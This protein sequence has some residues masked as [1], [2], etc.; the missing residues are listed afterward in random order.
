MAAPQTGTARTVADMSILSKW[1]VAT[2]HPVV[3][4]DLGA[5]HRITDGAIDRW[6]T[7]ATATYIA[8]CPKLEERRAGAGLVLSAHMSSHAGGMKLGGATSV[9]VS[10]TATEVFPRA[11]VIA[12]RIRPAGTESPDPLDLTCDIQLEDPSTGA[13][14]AI[15]NEI[16]DEL[17]AL[18]HA[19]RHYN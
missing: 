18:E 15:D 7:A 12:V 13:A 6:A 2:E 19:A 1:S 5:D 4:E 10:A 11:F 16:R 3:P 14:L 9:F 8:Q 17:I